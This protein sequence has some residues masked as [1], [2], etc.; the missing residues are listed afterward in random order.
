MSLVDQPMGEVGRDKPF[1]PLGTD[2]EW[3]KMNEKSSMMLVPPSS[4]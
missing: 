3:D 1:F 2:L 4:L